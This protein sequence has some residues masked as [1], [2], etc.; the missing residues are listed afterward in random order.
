MEVSCFVA[1]LSFIFL[2]LRSVYPQET[3]RSL[4]L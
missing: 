1:A 2:F 4:T 3:P